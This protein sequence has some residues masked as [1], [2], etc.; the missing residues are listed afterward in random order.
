M[1]LLL[2]ALLGL[3]IQSIGTLVGRVLI[4]LGISYVAYK[5]IDT[6]VGSVKDNLISSISGLSPIALQLAG[7]LTDDSITAMVF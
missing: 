3:I 5:G 1:P 7:F 4:S 6:L 2:G